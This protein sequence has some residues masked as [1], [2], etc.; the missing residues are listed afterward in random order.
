MAAT[1]ARQGIPLVMANARLSE[2]TYASTSKFVWL[3][4]PAYASLTAVWAQSAADARRFD[5]L[6]A[7]VQ[8]VFGNIKFDASVDVVRLAQGRAW[9]AKLAGPVLMFASSREGE[10]LQLLA[11]LQKIR[12]NIPLAGVNVD[13]DAIKYVVNS[14]NTAP[15]TDKPVQWLIVPRHPQR[16]DPVADL[17]RAQGFKVS[18]RSEWP[19]EG[20]DSYDSANTQTIWLGDSLGEM[21]LYY[22]LSDVALLGG[23]FEPLGGQNLIEAAACGCPV[24]MGPST[25]NFAEVA[26]MAVQ[27]GAALQVD[28]LPLAV[29]AAETLLETEGTLKIARAAA[30]T[31]ATAHQ[32]AA[33]KTA[34]AIQ[35][36]LH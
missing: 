12:S 34:A 4:R 30:S 1:C 32:G 5:A 16:F 33:D 6:G 14:E 25:F 9:R 22:G 27:A 15:E 28:A 31:F 3:A 35:A 11:Y 29:Q 8:G 21:A 36:L 7:P 24:V 10:E 26:Q 17:I 18:R 13:Y 23:S 2:K 19:S 20:P